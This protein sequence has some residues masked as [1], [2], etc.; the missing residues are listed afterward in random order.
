[1]LTAIAAGLLLQSLQAATALADREDSMG[2]WHWTGWRT[3]RPVTAAWGCA[4]TEG[5]AHLVALGAQAQGRWRV[6]ASLQCPMPLPLPR[7]DS[8]EEAAAISAP[9]L[10][11][12][13]RSPLVRAHIEAR[14]CA[15]SLPRAHC[16]QA[17]S[18]WPAHWSEDEVAAQVQ[19]EAAAALNLPP[20]AVSYDFL[21]GVP[22][23][24]PQGGQQP[25]LWAACARAALQPVRQAFRGLPLKLLAVEPA[26]AAAQRAW[27]HLAEG[28]SALWSL[29]VNDWHFEL[30]PA[31]PRPDLPADGLD[32]PQLVACGLALAPLQHANGP[33][34]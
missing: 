3:H 12:A 17:Q 9:A 8:D 19:V 30:A 18:A 1:M 33:D 15:L 11:E 7:D 10:R 29:A 31:S 24:V 4:L 14:A 20:Q 5:A 23:G 2:S 27:R 22:Q 13:L 6:L 34:A 16:V 26:E 28:P 25:W 21:P 32:H